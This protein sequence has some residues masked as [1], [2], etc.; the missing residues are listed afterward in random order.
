MK[1]IKKICWP[2]GGEF[3][4]RLHEWR[5]QRLWGPLA[6]WCALGGR[7]AFVP[8]FSFRVR[9]VARLGWWFSSVCWRCVWLGELRRAGFG[10]E[11]LYLRSV[12]PFPWQWARAWGAR[13]LVAPAT[14]GR[15]LRPPR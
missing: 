1:Q 2:F 13:A 5:M 12:Q 14:G 10:R 7:W 6:L 8:Q 15:P 3:Q 9:L 11:A 4:L